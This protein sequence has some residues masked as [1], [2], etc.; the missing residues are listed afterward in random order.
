MSVGDGER[1]RQKAL[2]M[3][4]VL[5]A[6]DSSMARAFI[7][8]TLEMVCSED[9]EVIEARD[10]EDAFAQMK[11]QQPD[12][13]ITDL[14]MPVMDGASLLKRVKSSPRLHDTP[15]IV[16]TSLLN[17]AKEKELQS[18]DVSAILGKPLNT[19]ALSKALV[20]VF[21]NQVGSDDGYG[22]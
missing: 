17:P 7:K 22:W 18:Y 3:K 11:A 10:G 14:N 2:Y 9:V 8:R 1:E 4:K 19:A 6:D 16:I 15:C 21:P 12:L 13:L 20:D 5:V